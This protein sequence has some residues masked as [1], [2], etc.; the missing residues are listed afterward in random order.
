MVVES[1]KLLLVQTFYSKN[2]QLF[3]IVEDGDKYTCNLSL[4]QL[5][6]LKINDNI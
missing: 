3:D 1:L 6:E 4:L 5:I 2:L